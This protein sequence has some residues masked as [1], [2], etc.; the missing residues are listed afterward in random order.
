MNLVLVLL[1]SFALYGVGRLVVAAGR[2]LVARTLARWS[3]ALEPLA[4]PC[5]AGLGM[6][7]EIQQGLLMI[8]AQIDI[9]KIRQTII[10]QY[11][12]HLFRGL[13]PIDIVTQVE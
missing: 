11:F 6:F 2:R 1:L 8:S 7:Q 9:L 10:Q 5:K 12:N 4:A 13:S 3:E